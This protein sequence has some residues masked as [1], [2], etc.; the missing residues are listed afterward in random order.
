MWAV[1]SLLHLKVVSFISPTLSQEGAFT[2]RLRH[3]PPLTLR[4]TLWKE[5]RGV[6]RYSAQGTL[7]RQNVNVHSPCRK[8][9]VPRCSGDPLCWCNFIL[10]LPLDHWLCYGLRRRGI[11]NVSSGYKLLFTL[12]PNEYV[13]VSSKCPAKHFQSCICISSPTTA[14]WNGG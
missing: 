5:S 11:T 10:A 13:G 9:K 14:F 12:E 6:L 8:E 2:W 4:K 3:A 1:V 7:S